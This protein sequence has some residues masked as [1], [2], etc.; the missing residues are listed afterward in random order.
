MK[1]CLLCVLLKILVC[2]F[3]TADKCSPNLEDKT[4]SF[5]TTCPTN[6]SQEPPRIDGDNTFFSCSI[7]IQKDVDQYRKVNKKQFLQKSAIFDAPV[8]Q[9]VELY[10]KQFPGHQSE[11]SLR[12]NFTLPKGIESSWRLPQAVLLKFKALPGKRVDKFYTKCPRERI[13]QFHNYKAD[14]FYDVSNP[15]RNNLFPEV[16]KERQL[17]FD[18]MVGLEGNVYAITLQTAEGKNAT[19]ITTVT[20]REE[21]GLNIWHPVIMTYLNKTDW[22]LYVVVE[23][24]PSG[25][26]VQSYRIS[27]VQIWLGVIRTTEIDLKERNSTVFSNL[28]K[29]QYKV[30]VTPICRTA[31]KKPVNH[32]TESA[33]IDAGELDSEEETLEPMKVVAMVAGCIMGVTLLLS[34]TYCIR[35]RPKCQENSHGSVPCGLL[36]HPFECHSTTGEYDLVI[37]LNRYIN[38]ACDCTVTNYL[39]LQLQRAE[40]G[41]SEIVDKTLKDCTFVLVLY[42]SNC[43]NADAMNYDTDFYSCVLKAAVDRR[44]SHNDIRIIPLRFLFNSNNDVSTVISS[45]NIPAVNFMDDP[46][47]VYCKIHGLDKR[48]P[49]TKCL[50]NENSSQFRDMWSDLKGTVDRVNRNNYD[51]EHG[52]SERLLQQY[53]ILGETAREIPVLPK[54]VDKP[55]GKVTGKRQ[56]REIAMMNA[57]TDSLIGKQETVHSQ[58][59][60]KLFEGYTRS[61]NSCHPHTKENETSKIKESIRRANYEPKLESHREQFEKA[62]SY[63]AQ[64]LNQRNVQMCEA[65][66][67]YSGENTVTSCPLQSRQPDLHCH[68]WQISLPE[69]SA[70]QLQSSGKKDEIHNKKFRSEK[71][72]LHFNNKRDQNE[73]HNEFVP[74]M[75]FNAEDSDLEDFIL[76][77]PE[78]KDLETGDEEEGAHFLGRHDMPLFLHGNLHHHP[79]HCQNRVFDHRNPAHSNNIFHEVYQSQLSDQPY[80]HHHGNMHFRNQRPHFRPVMTHQQMFHHGHS[81]FHQYQPDDYIPRNHNHQGGLPAEH[82]SNFDQENFSDH[83]HC[84]QQQKH[85]LN[86]LQ[87]PVEHFNEPEQCLMPPVAHEQ[88]M[89]NCKQD[90]TLQSPTLNFDAVDPPNDLM[91]GTDQTAGI[92]K[93]VENTKQKVTDLSKASS[94]HSLPTELEG[95]MWIKPDDFGSDSL[96]PP[97][98]SPEPPED[99]DNITDSQILD[100]M[101]QINENNT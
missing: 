53:G 43:F 76:G 33:I 57:E 2:S 7:G 17:M 52:E 47:K 9:G 16:F 94:V 62:E 59:R 99:L 38:E 78:R 48:P 5:D 63:S 81:S 58:E 18:C 85:H 46:D 10:W 96:Q 56:F 98:Y 36:L 74:V 29:G 42:T 95:C 25:Y 31:C 28:K 93:K 39:D 44:R 90:M 22:S 77:E 83:H 87:H 45:I 79:Y 34:I 54:E 49:S 32:S 12:F 21:S 67:H 6:C 101:M 69:D 84:H 86:N 14:S 15:K 37:K 1:K 91:K 82:L 100:Q 4:I 55:V 88:I 97:S 66:V 8:I 60:A 89:N 41:Q 64:K 13:F 61:Q 68:G 30:K 26:K 24:P 72:Q 35:Q 80:L 20:D 75:N 73:G 40:V 50:Q 11:Q 65:E 23:K 27:L 3:T 19:Y 71:H 51:V 92:D 70:H